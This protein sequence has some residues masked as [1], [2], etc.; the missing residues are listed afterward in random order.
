MVR[1]L[2]CCLI[3]SVNSNA[4]TVL[5]GTNA[6]GRTNVFLLQERPSHPTCS[7]WDP[8]V[9]KSD[10]TADLAARVSKHDVAV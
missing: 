3:D 8:A 7:R 5:G 6:H 10:S 9:R 4:D 2:Q 1:A